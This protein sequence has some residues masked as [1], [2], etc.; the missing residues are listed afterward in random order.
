MT[1]EEATRNTMNGAV[2]MVALLARHVV[3]T[4][5]GLCGDTSMPF[6]DALHKNAL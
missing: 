6:F 2:A 4:I 1:S 5:L 3:E